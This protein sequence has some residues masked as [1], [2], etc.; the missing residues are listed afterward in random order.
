MANKRA[1]GPD[2]AQLGLAVAIE[3]SAVPKQGV[4]LFKRASG[5]GFGREWKNP[6]ANGG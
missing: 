6:I 2:K 3:R 1:I 5:V 4:R